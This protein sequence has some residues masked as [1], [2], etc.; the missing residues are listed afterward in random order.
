MR[1]NIL[2]LLIC[3]CSTQVR[4]VHP[5]MLVGRDA[6]LVV[7]PC[8]ARGRAPISIGRFR[9]M[10]LAIGQRHMQSAVPRCPGHDTLICAVDTTGG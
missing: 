7:L 8:G 6:E 9:A 3:A 5:D 4:G 2:L 1:F 10:N